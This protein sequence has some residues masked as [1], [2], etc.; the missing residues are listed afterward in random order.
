MAEIRN[1]FIH[2]VFFW[3]REP[4]NKNE[5]ELIKGLKKL[6]SVTTIKDF[7]IGKPALTNREVIE[8]SYSISWCV[9]FNSATDQD[10]YQTDPIH[11][12]FVNECSHLWSKVIVHD[13]IDA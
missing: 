1:K 12:A 2:H 8:R 4:G 5:G 13:S 9:F 6:S 10:S 11:L 7:H 3:L